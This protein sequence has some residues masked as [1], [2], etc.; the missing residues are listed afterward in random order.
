M[1]KSICFWIIAFVA[2][3][4]NFAVAASYEKA[5]MLNQHGLNK[6][7]KTELIEVL[8]GKASEQEKAKAYY[9]LGSIAFAENRIAVALDTWRELVKKYASSKEA[10]LVIDRITEL[11]EI[12]GDIKQESIKNAVAQSY[13]R[14]G[15]FWSRG[16]DNKFMIDSSWIQNVEASIKWYDR[17]IKEFPGTSA[18]RLAYEDKIRAII[19]WKEPGRYGSSYG[20]EESFSKHMPLLLET[21]QNC[22]KEHP[23][24]S[25]LQ[26]FR[27]QIAQA[28]W[29]N[30]DWVKT[31]E[32]LNMIIKKAGEII[33]IP[34]KEW[35]DIK[36]FFYEFIK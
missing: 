8:L 13:L 22:E 25:T 36:Q 11:A 26:A 21:L 16:K 12:V 6:G 7:A 2:L 34:N 23:K 31:R 28:Y 9:L 24:A 3:Y 15:D 5:V 29:K 1:K 4:A 17:V 27:Y 19:G 33:R 20:L 14:H 30:K 10:S 18:S 32:W 35:N